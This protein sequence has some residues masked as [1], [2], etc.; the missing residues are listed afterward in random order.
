MLEPPTTDRHG[1]AHVATEL[2]AVLLGWRA[3]P[4]ARWAC[5]VA[6][7]SGAGKT[8]LAA[9]L[10]AALTRAGHPTVTL[11]L[12]DYFHLPPRENHAAR[13]LDIQRVGPGEVDLRRLD[14]DLQ[15]FLGGASALSVPVCEP[16][17]DRFGTRRLSL[18]SAR[19]LLVEGTWALRLT[20]PAHRVML[21]ADFRITRARRTQRGR[22]VI[23]AVT[24]KILAREHALLA[25]DRERAHVLIAPDGTVTS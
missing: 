20:R 16:E 4:A 15:R 10:A 25:T 2:C 22:D 17:Q 11:H 19:V 24:P 6:G 7:E 3:D 9:A 13:R 18:R 14:A 23:D 1:Y 8:T 12:D 21:T 5:A